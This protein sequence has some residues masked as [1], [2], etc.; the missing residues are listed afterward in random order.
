MKITARVLGDV[1]VQ[2]GDALAKL[3]QV[4][5]IRRAAFGVR[6][7]YVA[8]NASSG[9][10]PVVNG[11]SLANVV[12]GASRRI[13]GGFLGFRVV[14]AVGSCPNGH[15]GSCTFGHK[16]ARGR[17]TGAAPWPLAAWHE[18]CYAH[19]ATLQ[20]RGWPDRTPGFFSR[21]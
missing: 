10:P 15:V 19:A 1:T 4:D 13:I 16:L 3:L 12:P 21:D 5:L 9:S 20:A 2:G 17:A 7:R 14:L 11:P 6:G 18:A 8:R